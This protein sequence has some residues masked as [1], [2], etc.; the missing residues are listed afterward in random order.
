MTKSFIIAI[1]TLVVFSGLQA[2]DS[3][4]AQYLGKYRFPD[5][6]VVPEV[7]VAMENGNLMMNSVSG[8]SSLQLIKGD[9][10]AIPTFNGSAT[11]KRNEKQKVN[12]VHIEAMGYILDGTKDSV[13]NAWVITWKV[14]DR[15][16]G[17]MALVSAGR[18]SHSL[19][20]YESLNFPG[21]KETPLKL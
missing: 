6:S 13:A 4:F 12:G 14:K 11:F 17:S 21:R 16:S 18:N 9:S 10:F 19:R 15:A 7:E 8:S 20:Q 3:S 1:V 5:G 2:Q